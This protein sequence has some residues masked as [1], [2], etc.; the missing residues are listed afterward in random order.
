MPKCQHR[1]ISGDADFEPNGLDWEADIKDMETLIDT[2][3]NDLGCPSVE[4]T[5]RM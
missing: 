4:V 1:P 3:A 5:S 2:A